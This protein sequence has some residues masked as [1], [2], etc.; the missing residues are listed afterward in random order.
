MPVLVV[1]VGSSS[2]RLRL[3]GDDD[4]VMA[5]RHLG[6]SKIRRGRALMV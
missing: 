3:L 1:N 5:H 2:V 4:D 6:S